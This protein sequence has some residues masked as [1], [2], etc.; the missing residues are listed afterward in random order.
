MHNEWKQTFNIG[1][2][3]TSKA[4]FNLFFCPHFQ[5]RG[6]GRKNKLRSKRKFTSLPHPPIQKKDDK[7]VN[8]NF[9]DH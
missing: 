2:Y 4:S 9:S 5:G 8:T 6:T 7:K 1:K 3:L